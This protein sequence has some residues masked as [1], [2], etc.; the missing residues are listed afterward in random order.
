[1][2]TH[3]GG[4]RCPV[5]PTS[6]QRSTSKLIR[7]PPYHLV[8]SGEIDRRNATYL[9]VLEVEIARAAAKYPCKF[10]QWCLSSLPAVVSS[11]QASSTW[12]GEQGKTNPTQT[13]VFARRTST[14]RFSRTLWKLETFWVNN[15]RW[16]PI[17]KHS[18]CVVLPKTSKSGA[19]G[20]LLA[21]KQA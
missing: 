16:R 7:S 19:V 8:F 15:T 4:C 2:R 21:V 11:L 10:W 9:T 3:F 20:R 6:A 5:T 18:G 14:R 13:R 1:M 12:R 17:I